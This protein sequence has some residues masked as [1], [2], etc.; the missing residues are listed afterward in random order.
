[1]LDVGRLRL[2]VDS[3]VVAEGGLIDP[4][5]L[6]SPIR[7]L[8]QSARLGHREPRGQGHSLP[9]GPRRDAP[10][11]RH[12]LIERHLAPPHGTD[13]LG[14]FGRPLGGG[15]HVRRQRRSDATP[16]SEVLVRRP[17]AV[18]LPLLRV[19]EQPDRQIDQSTVLG[20]EVP[21]HVV[22]QRL[23]RGA[24]DHIDRPLRRLS[25]IVQRHDVIVHV[26]VFNVNNDSIFLGGCR[27]VGN[28]TV[29]WEVAPWMGNR[30]VGWEVA[31]RDR[32]PAINRRHVDQ[33]VPSSERR[34]V[35][36]FVVAAGCHLTARGRGHVRMDSVWPS[37]GMA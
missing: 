36:C 2:S 30:T 17:H 37:T 29:G 27:G 24:V 16:P 1:M 6:P 9:I 25:E 22:Q 4:A 34:P 33:R 19:S 13:G 14:Q 15:D 21:G 35:D 11:D 12:Q 31:Q 20:V 26:F 8:D 5:R 10:H 32:S 23:E 3:R 7:L 28:R 18:A